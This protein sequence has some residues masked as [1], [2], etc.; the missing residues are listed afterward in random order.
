MDWIATFLSIIAL[1]ALAC[2]GI[3]AIRFIVSDD[4]GGSGEGIE[5]ES[6]GREAGHIEET[7]FR[8]ERYPTSW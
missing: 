5:A 3:S 6:F 2:L 1:D 7:G 8:E 4:D